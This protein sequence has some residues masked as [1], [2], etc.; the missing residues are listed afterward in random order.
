MWG[1]R[2]RES[3]IPTN[4]L[5]LR[6]LLSMVPP[7]GDKS[8]L[9]R[10]STWQSVTTIADQKTDGLPLGDAK[11]AITD[12]Y[13]DKAVFKVFGPSHVRVTIG[14]S[15][16]D[17]Y[18][19]KG[20]R[21]LLLKPMWGSRTSSEITD[22][23]QLLELLD[24]APP[25]GEKSVGKFK[26]TSQTAKPESQTT[27]KAFDPNRLNYNELLVRGKRGQL[28][29][30]L[31][32]A[33]RRLTSDSTD[34]SKREALTYLCV[35]LAKEAESMGIEWGWVSHPH[36]HALH[37]EL[38][39][40]GQLTFRT[41]ER[42]QGHD[43]HLGWDGSHREEDRLWDLMTSVINSQAFG[44]SVHPDDLMFFGKHVGKPMHSLP[45]QYIKWLLKWEGLRS[46]WSISG[47]LKALLRAH[48][49]PI[50]PV[51][52]QQLSDP[53]PNRV[54][55]SVTNQLVDPPFVPGRFF[56]WLDGTIERKPD[57]DS[58]YS[59]SH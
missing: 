43:F 3:G 59:L 56:H 26:P 30:G 5:H 17:L 53:A 54:E 15:V 20:K 35:F 13:G 29:A 49:R 8:L 23:S 11:A 31:F 47:C 52:E 7:A 36:D 58:R 24:A 14:R 25:V 40:H 48:D 12:K 51:T 39:A 2:R 4:E 16:F 22:A 50:D 21:R 19:N 10:D 27:P 1:L 42:L 18:R 44:D 41:S 6:A 34:D 57:T 32:R 9:T 55:V 46:W 33:F 37:V 28:A 38:P 45:V